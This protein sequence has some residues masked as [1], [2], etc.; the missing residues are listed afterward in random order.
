VKLSRL[1][2][3]SVCVPSLA[4]AH[5]TI[6]SG[7]AAANKSQKITFAINH[8]CTDASNNKLDTLSIQ[9]DI[10]A[11]IDGTTVRPMPS[12]FAPTP[13]VTKTGT[14]VTSV[15]WTRNAA[16]LE[17]GDNSYYE[18]TLKLKVND[19]PYTKIPFVMTQVCRPAG[20]TPADDVTV[21]WT[22]PS[23]NPEPSPN[24]V[25]VPAHSSGWN[26]LT[27]TA[28]VAAADLGTYFGDAQI[29]WKGAAAFSPNATVSALIGMTPGVT[30]LSADLAAGDEIWV[31]Y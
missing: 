6:S 26:K 2:T 12:D 21:V 27:M 28:A 13:V 15:K 7:T 20:G 24:L 5:I 19:V 9:V 31:K 25:V 3:L 8:G 22:G 18:I 17:N 11:S 29:V 23:T 4:A 10:P 1:V 30:L 16:D 14:A